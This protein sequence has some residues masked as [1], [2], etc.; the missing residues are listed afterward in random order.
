MTCSLVSIVQADLLAAEQ[1]ARDASKLGAEST[2]LLCNRLRREVEFAF[3]SHTRN[4]AG[5]DATCY[6]PSHSQLADKHSH[7]HAGLLTKSQ[8]QAVLHDLG[9]L[10]NKPAA[11]SST[12]PARPAI[13]SP[14]TARHAQQ[15]ARVVDRLWSCLHTSQPANHATSSA[16]DSP[17]VTSSLVE[18]SNHPTQDSLHDG[19]P[20]ALL[21]EGLDVWEQLIGA[22]SSD[23]DAGLS[24]GSQYVLQ[25]QH[26]VQHSTASHTR[27]D[28][29]F[30][31]AHSMQS[32]AAASKQHSGRMAGISLQQLMHFVQL[33]QQCS[34]A[35]GI[36][37]LAQPVQGLAHQHADE[38]NRLACICS[39]NKQTNM[40][41]T[42]IGKPKMCRQPLAVVS[43]HDIRALHSARQGMHSPTQKAV[44]AEVR[45]WRPSGTL[46]LLRDLAHSTALIV[47]HKHAVCTQ[48]A[49]MLMVTLAA[50]L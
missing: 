31:T 36:Q 13:V 17:L 32:H 49:L 1:A 35:V 37:L 14:H 30:R 19:R 7:S 28:E 45:H 41:Y 5:S 34:S 39:R 22:A 21:M 8:L 4:S 26:H 9:L 27:V 33:V 16:V 18:V 23:A 44:H 29:A 3:H 12:S 2:V 50:P 20:D 10:E 46:A 15:Q 48:Y 24:E 40:A 11:F 25:K 6:K 47:S 43:S 42:G 38:L